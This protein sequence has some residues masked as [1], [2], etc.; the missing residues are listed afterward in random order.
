VLPM[1]GATRWTSSTGSTGCI[2]SSREGA[3]RSRSR[4]CANGSGR[5]RLYVVS[6]S[7]TEPKLEDSIKAPAGIAW[8]EVIEVQ[9][10]WLEVDAMAQPMRVEQERADYHEDRR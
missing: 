8:H 5:Y 10:Y 7:D 2:A 9:H 4:I 6:H 3:R 1:R